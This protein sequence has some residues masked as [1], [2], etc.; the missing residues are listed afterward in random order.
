MFLSLH[1]LFQAEE[2]ERLNLDLFQLPIAAIW[3]HKEVISASAWLLHLTFWWLPEHSNRLTSCQKPACSTLWCIQHLLQLPG[4]PSHLVESC[5]FLND[6]RD[7]THSTRS[8][9]TMYRCNIY[10]DSIYSLMSRRSHDTA[11]AQHKSHVACDS[12]SEE[13]QQPSLVVKRYVNKSSLREKSSLEACGDGAIHRHKTPAQ[14]S[15]SS[16]RN[17]RAAPQ[18]FIQSFLKCWTHQTVFSIRSTRDCVDHFSFFSSSYRGYS[19]PV[20]K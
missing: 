19:Q 4:H 20:E 5:L 6:Q 18:N 13:D 7:R 12:T 3:N 16:E 9:S 15:E 2:W 1:F 17:D 11:V 8:T 10:K 14:R